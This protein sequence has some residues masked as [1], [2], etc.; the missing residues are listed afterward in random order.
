M[1]GCQKE[2]VFGLDKLQK[3][4]NEG[5]GK[6]KKKERGAR[7]EEKRRK[8]CTLSFYNGYLGDVLLLD[9]KGPFSGNVFKN[10]ARYI[11]IHIFSSPEH[12]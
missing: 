4:T 10:P 2:G 9:G 3:H 6:E 5:K 12:F 11:N 1:K 8:Q 7:K